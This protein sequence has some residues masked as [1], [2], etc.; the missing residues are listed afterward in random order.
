M[1]FGLGVPP[2]RPHSLLPLAAELRVPGAFYSLDASPRQKTDRVSASNPLRLSLMKSPPCPEG[3]PFFRSR[4]CRENKKRREKKRK[5][6]PPG[7]R[8]ET[9][10]FTFM[11][12]KS[13]M[14]CGEEAERVRRPAVLTLSTRIMPPPH[15]R[16]RVFIAFS[17]PS[18]PQDNQSTAAI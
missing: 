13:F 10:V 17:V 2:S 8:Q 9:D 14:L 4:R 6:N 18:A 1:V 3:A 7:R 5:S 16:R 15:C 12:H 11:R